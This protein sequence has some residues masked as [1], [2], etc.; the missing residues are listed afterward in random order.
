MS[1]SFTTV[2]A[3]LI[4]KQEFVRY[5][6]GRYLG[7]CCCHVS[8]PTASLKP[9]M[10]LYSGLENVPPIAR[11]L[12]SGILQQGYSCGYLLA[13]G[14]C[15]PFF[16]TYSLSQLTT[17]TVIN[18]TVVQQSKYH[19]RTI[20]FFG[21]GLSLL[22]AIVRAC[23]PESQQFI[24]AREEAKAHGISS[25][26]ATKNFMRELGNMFRTNCEFVQKKPEGMI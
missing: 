12:C 19:W 21:A 9:V 26:Q 23:L 10:T 1:C 6:H 15:Q 16:C 13:A 4:D 7:M 11:G 14:M 8:I 18:L 24:V 17:F 5:C 22:A 2:R 25:K 20:Y 3:M